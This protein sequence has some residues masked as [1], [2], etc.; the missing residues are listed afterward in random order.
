MSVYLFY[1][2]DYNVLICKQ[3][4]CALSSKSLTRHFL[5]EHEPNLSIQQSIHNYAEQYI[6]TKA[7]DLTYSSETIYPIPYLSIVDGFQCQY[8]PCDKILS[9]LASMKVH[10]RVDHGWKAKDEERWVKTRAQTFYQGND[11]RYMN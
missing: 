10:C 9:T 6:V 7:A 3:H 4:Q 1:N 8:E 5:E 2:N 11:R